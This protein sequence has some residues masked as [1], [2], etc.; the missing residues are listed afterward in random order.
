MLKDKITYYVNSKYIIK[1]HQCIVCQILYTN[2]Y[3]YTNPDIAAMKLQSQ[4]NI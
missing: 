2:P 1:D 3:I 4:E